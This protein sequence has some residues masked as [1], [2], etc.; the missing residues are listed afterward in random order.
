MGS[1]MSYVGLRFSAKLGLE[2]SDWPHS[3]RQN[4]CGQWQPQGHTNKQEPTTLTLPYGSNKHHCMDKE[5]FH[6][7]C[8]VMWG[9]FSAKLVLEINFY[10]HWQHIHIHQPQAFTSI[11]AFP[12]SPDHQTLPPP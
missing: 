3:S 11:T 9:W 8:Y 4:F 12:S 7:I 2:I 5:E 6:G 1:V 10:G